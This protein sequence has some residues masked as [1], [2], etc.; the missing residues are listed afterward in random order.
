MIIDRAC[1]AVGEAWLRKPQNCKRCCIELSGVR[2]RTLVSFFGPR[3]RQFA[4]GIPVIR[5]ATVA[6]NFL[7]RRRR[8]ASTPRPATASKSGP[9]P[10]KPSMRFLEMQPRVWTSSLE[11]SADR[12]RSKRL[13]SVAAF[14]NLSLTSSFPTNARSSERMLGEYLA[15][16]AVEE[17][18]CTAEQSFSA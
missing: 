4:G 18:Q 16:A 9:P 15:T 13:I 6:A 3:R 8:R 12:G 2:C 5:A 10:Q 11:Q 1:R 17:G 14:V 7:R